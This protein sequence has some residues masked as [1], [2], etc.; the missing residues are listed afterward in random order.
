[1]NSSAQTGGAALRAARRLMQRTG[2]LQ[3]VPRVARALEGIDPALWVALRS[4]REQPPPA[5]ALVAVYR[6]RNSAILGRLM[7]TLPPGSPIA[8]W[9]L[10]EVAGELR[11]QTCGSG[12]GQR[13]ALLNR[14]IEALQAPADAWLV[15]SDDDV[16]F[17]RG[18][19]TGAARIAR[20]AGL[21]LSQPAHAWASNWNWRYTRRRWLGIARRGHFVEIGPLFVLSPE[22]RRLV[23]PLPADGGMGWG[24]EARWAALQLRGLR[25]GIV[26]AVLMNHLARAAA[27]YERAPEYEREL[28]LRSAFG[29]TEMSDLQQ[30]LERWTL[31]N[32]L[33]SGPA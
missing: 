17:T 30:D 11:G 21:Y 15:V 22:G 26:D 3:W 33:A 9:A 14:C 27:N 31:L 24:T 12:P 20:A 18:D 32:H 23:L 2:T 19:A 5:L 29:V 4:L 16:E 25:L 1:V 8:L 6:R 28:A 10:D 7:A 13:F